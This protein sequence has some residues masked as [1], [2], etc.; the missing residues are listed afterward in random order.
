MNKYNLLSNNDGNDATAIEAST[1][2]EAVEEALVNL[3]WYV[4]NDGDCYVGVSGSDP[5]NIF[6]LNEQNFEDAQ[7]E[8]I[9]KLGYYVTSSK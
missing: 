5:N 9:E 8:V 1:F 3:N 7:Y 6:E 2:Q 4:V